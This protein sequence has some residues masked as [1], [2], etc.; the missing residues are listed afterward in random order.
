MMTQKISGTDLTCTRLG[1]G[2]MRSVRT[3]NPADVT[4]QRHD[5]AVA[6]HI[7][8][9]ELG[10]TLFDTAD[11]YCRGS[12]E[13]AMGDAFKRVSGLRDRVVLATK[14]GIR[15]AGDPTPDAPHRYDFSADHIRWSCDQSLKRLGVTTIDLYQLHRPDVLMQPAEIAQAFDD[16]HQSGKVRYVGVSNFSPSQLA[17]LQ[18]HCRQKLV[19]NQ[20]EI[21][22]GRL[23]CFVDG[24]LD[25]CIE[26]QITPLSWSPLGGGWLGAGRTPAPGDANYPIRKLVVDELDAQARSFDVSRTCVALAWLLKHPAGIIPIVGST[27]VD[28]LKDMTRSTTLDMSREQWYRIYLAARGKALP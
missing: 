18:A 10:Y 12:C 8:A 13:L 4:P 23:D 5:D 16:L 11:I 2:N 19:V 17:M 6:Q 15:F 24:T 21:H 14:C 22:A 3:W 9:Y 27:R 1:Y 25:Q 28:S 7:A 20:V 26:R